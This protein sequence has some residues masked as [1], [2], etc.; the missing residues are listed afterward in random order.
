MCGTAVT[1]LSITHPP[2]HKLTGEEISNPYL[3]IEDLFDYC[4]LHQWQKKLWNS[5]K[6]NITGI[7]PKE[8]NRRERNEVVYLHE[9]LERLV[10]AAWVI[11]EKQRSSTP[12]DT[13]AP[14]LYPV[15]PEHIHG[16]AIEKL[17]AGA[18]CPAAGMQA[19]VP[20]IARLTHADQI[21][22]LGIGKEAGTWQY[23]FLS[24]LPGNAPLSFRE[25]QTAVEA[26]CSEHGSIILWCAHTGEVCRQLKEGH[27]F[28]STACTARQRVYD[29]ERVSLPAPENIDV[30]RVVQKARGVFDP[31]FTLAQSFLD[32]ARYHAVHE[33]LKTAAFLLHQAAEHALRA[34]LLA[35]T[36]YNSYSHDLANLLRRY[37]YWAP[38]LL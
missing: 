26:Q 20:A 17:C 23:H 22:C 14:V 15:A 30:N 13:A 21:Y 4:H 6:S 32:G 9:Y 2:I 38:A 37:N 25:Y 33:Q 18:G 31:P 35:I 34:P 36:G 29:N 16:P 10:E 27:L 1:P 12:F 7:Y 24:L 19:I 5:F 28:Y 8:L 3:V 11:R